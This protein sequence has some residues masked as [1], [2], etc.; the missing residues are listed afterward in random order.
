MWL[1]VRDADEGWGDAG[2]RGVDGSG[3]DLCLAEAVA[4][5]SAHQ[6]AMCVGLV[7]VLPAHAWLVQLRWVPSGICGS[8]TFLAGLYVP[9]DGCW[10]C[11]VV[12]W[13][14]RGGGVGMQGRG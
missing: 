13:V 6:R 12:G 3:G 14:P 9:G 1:V 5:R 2:L 10:S 4:E 8:P 7:C 11:S